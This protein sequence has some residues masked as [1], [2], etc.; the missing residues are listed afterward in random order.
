MKE[1]PNS[2]QDILT[3]ELAGAVIRGLM[4]RTGSP[5]FDEDLEQEAL[6]RIL[7]AT[8][9]VGQ[10]QYP[11]AFAVKIVQNTVQDYWRKRRR[12]ENLESI[13]EKIL[14][15]RPAF[16]VQIDHA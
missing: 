11:K 3:S 4:R 1:R 14:S 5:L 8:R 12:F 13:P 6:L 10:I 9:R 2:F 7:Q 16:E 15:Y